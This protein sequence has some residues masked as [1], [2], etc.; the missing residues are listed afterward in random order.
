M[1]PQR[2]FFIL[3]TIHCFDVV[4]NNAEPHQFQRVIRKSKS[5]SQPV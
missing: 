3:M 2:I 1:M 5:Q 4:K